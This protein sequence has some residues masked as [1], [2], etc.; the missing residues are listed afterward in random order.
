[1]K[2][3]A[4]KDIERIGKAVR[5]RRE[6][7]GLSQDLSIYG[8]PK[9]NLV[10]GLET[11]AMWPRLPQT[12]ARWAYALQWKP[13]AFDRLLAGEEPEELNPSGPVIPTSTPGMAGAMPSVDE[14]ER[15]RQ[16]LEAA[17]AGHQPVRQ[18]DPR[19]RMIEA[20]AV[21]NILERVLEEVKT[22]LGVMDSM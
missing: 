21:V 10:G 22:E 6:M 14:I 5:E 11:R 19:G 13:D 16:V 17:I 15:A 8:G 2:D 4:K 3:P 18:P 9:R 7:L 12:R 1:M 20:H